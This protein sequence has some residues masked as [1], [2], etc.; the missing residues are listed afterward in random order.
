[1]ACSA[2]PEAIIKIINKRKP[3]ILKML[4]Y[5]IGSS[6]PSSVSMGHFAN[7][8]QLTAGSAAKA[9]GK[10]IHFSIENT[11][12]NAVAASTTRICPQQ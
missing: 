2:A 12:K 8:M 3:F 1:M 4:L 9:I 5:V 6:S 11:L 7:K 10:N